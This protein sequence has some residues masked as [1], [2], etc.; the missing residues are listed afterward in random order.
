MTKD[1]I[2][3]SKYNSAIFQ[4]TPMK[5]AAK[6]LFPRICRE[7]RYIGRPIS[8]LK[9]SGHRRQHA[10][11]VRRPSSVPG[12]RPLRFTI[13][14]MPSNFYNQPQLVLGVLSRF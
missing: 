8:P 3:M 11:S 14:Q 5:S 6:G 10:H 4:D 13:A 7:D 2:K 1:E 12:A 9:D